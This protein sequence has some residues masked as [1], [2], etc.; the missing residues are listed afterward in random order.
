MIVGVPKEIKNNEFRVGLTPGSVRD[1][2]G[3]GRPRG[4]AIFKK[5][6]GSQR[7]IPRLFTHIWRAPF[8][9][10]DKKQHERQRISP[11]A[12]SHH[13]TSD[14]APAGRLYRKSRVF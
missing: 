3:N 4:T 14:T 8:Y 7:L 5:G 9:A 6:A 11:P 12:V 2:P 10:G 13:G 1:G